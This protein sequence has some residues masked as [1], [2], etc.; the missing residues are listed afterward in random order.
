M[1][2]S[3][4]GSRYTG[5]L[6]LIRFALRRDRV[7]L[8]AWVLGI[9]FMAF[10]FTTA[11]PILFG[12]EEEL[13]ETAGG[14]LTQ[15]VVAIFGGP[16]YGL[17]D[18]T[19]P[20][21]FVGVYGLYVIV[22]A[23]LMSIL[24]VSRHTRTEE[25]SGRAEL[26]RA[27]PIGRMAPLTAALFVTLLA[28][29]ALSVLLSLV[30][31]G[32]GYEV[33]DSLLFGAGVGAAGLAFAGVAAITVQLTEFSRTASGLAGAALGAAYAIRLAGDSLEQGGALLSWFSPLAWSQQTRAFVD[34][35]WWPLLL[36]LAFAVVTVF[37]GYGLASRRDLGAGLIRPRPGPA[38]AT[39]RLGSPLRLAYR[40]QRGAIVGWIVV[41]AIWGVGNGVIVEP[42]V[43]GLGDVSADVLAIFGG[44]ESGTLLLDGYLSTM[45]VYD[46][47]LV[48][49]FVV[50]GVLSMR[51]EE[52]EGRTEAV[53][54]T[55]TS[56][57]AWLG[58]HLAVLAAGSILLLAVVGLTLGLGAAVGLGQA[59]VVWDV[60][61]SHMAYAPALLVV[62]AIAGLAYGVVPGATGLA[63]AV[64]GYCFFMGFF[65]PVLDMP[66][67]L[68]TLSPMEHIPR[69]PLE[70]FTA[71]PM[72]AL[73][74]V[75]L[76][77]SA[78]GLVA[79]RKRDLVAT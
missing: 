54:A 74:V 70:E 35:R 56:R 25:Q 22:L 47:A 66:R 16:G 52:F 10:Y 32:Q 50:L 49:I 48:G 13:A 15:G 40:L 28:N 27:G 72:L 2:T 43:D 36:S 8:P 53:L 37:I 61:A 59:E 14:F 31:I 39:P 77:V 29:L 51:S 65:A 38:G 3:T 55:A 62:L 17:E 73:T 20:R 21:L 7:K 76:A 60:T 46:A 6:H 68:V 5:T 58:S 23:A 11:L 24:M 71:S 57:W 1:S 78:A 4:T 18:L 41:L 67:W 26:M 45:A 69:I 42:V 63:W 33:A 9:S 75:A 12:G 19:F 34:A 64:V 44:D 79:F 30:L